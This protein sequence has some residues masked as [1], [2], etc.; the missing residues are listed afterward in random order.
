[1]ICARL[2][3]VEE[4]RCE[5]GSL[6]GNASLRGGVAERLEGA[7]DSDELG[8]LGRF[9]R[10][11]SSSSEYPPTVSPS[12]SISLVR[13][14]RCDADLGGTWNLMTRGLIPFFPGF[15]WTFVVLLPFGLPGPAPLVFGFAFFAFTFL[16]F[17]TVSIGSGG[18]SGEMI[19]SS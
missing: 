10:S 15:A 8:L 1:M 17:T 12:E 16:D 13:G 18:N 3:V 19:S 4:S 14:C 6:G 11:S 9:C 7:E 5:R 2:V